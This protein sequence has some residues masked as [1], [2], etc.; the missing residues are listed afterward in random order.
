M[1]L[2]YAILALVLAAAVLS[3][4]PPKAPPVAMPP[5]A[6]PVTIIDTPAPVVADSPFY[7]STATGPGTTVR[8]AGGV[9]TSGP[10]VAGRMRTTTPALRVIRGGITTAN[11]VSG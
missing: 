6:P 4:A 8:S 3:A 5:K 11:C 9:L 2:L 1:R 10:A 7:S